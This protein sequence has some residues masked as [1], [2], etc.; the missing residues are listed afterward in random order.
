MK[1]CQWPLPLDSVKVTEVRRRCHLSAAHHRQ[2]SDRK[3]FIVGTQ[4]RENVW[5]AEAVSWR[6]ISRKAAFRL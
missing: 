5:A 4:P 2:T 3:D 6:R 1:H